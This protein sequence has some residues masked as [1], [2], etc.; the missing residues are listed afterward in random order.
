[1]EYLSQTEVGETVKIFEKYGYPTLALPAMM[2][3]LGVDVS[4]YNFSTDGSVS[5]MPRA[6]AD[7]LLEYARLASI[8][9]TQ[10]KHGINPN[11]VHASLP[12]RSAGNVTKRMALDALK[13]VMGGFISQ[14]INTAENGQPVD[15]SGASGGALPNENYY[16]AA[17]RHACAKCGHHMRVFQSSDPFDD[18]TVVRYLCFHCG[19][20]D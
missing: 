16:I 10:W 15:V 12:D 1:M 14:I 5:K 4:R 17:S 7:A 9:K 8:I 3:R 13:I 6:L 20:I 19:S 11:A 18:G 2:A